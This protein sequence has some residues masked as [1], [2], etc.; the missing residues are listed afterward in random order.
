V[1]RRSTPGTHGI[2]HWVIACFQKSAMD[3]AWSS[4]CPST[5]HADRSID[6]GCMDASGWALECL[7]NLSPLASIATGIWAYLGTGRSRACIIA[8]CAAVL[9]SRSAPL[10][11]WLTFPASSTAHASA[12]ATTLSRRQMMISPTS[13]SRM[14]LC[15]P[16]TASVNLSCPVSVQRSA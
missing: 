15:T 7:L 14:I 13:F 5:C 9:P 6:K 4:G 2:C 16:W 10:T 1:L 8:I 11:T 12:Y 3:V